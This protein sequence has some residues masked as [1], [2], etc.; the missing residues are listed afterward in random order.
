MSSEVYNR[1]RVVTFTNVGKHVANNGIIAT[2]IV[3]DVLYRG[4][5]SGNCDAVAV[6]NC[7]DDK[8]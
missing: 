7:R 6:T 1:N 5:S 2:N 8:E 4:Y 3:D